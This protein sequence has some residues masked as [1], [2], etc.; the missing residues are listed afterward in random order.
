MM[1]YAKKGYRVFFSRITL[2]DKLGQEYE[3]YIFAALNSAKVMLA[4]GTS[5]DYYNAVWVK[6]EWSRYLQ[7]MTQ[8]KSK[9]LIPCYKDIDA[10]DMPKEFTKLQAQAMGK[11]GAVQDLIRGIEKL[12]FVN[13]PKNISFNSGN[14]FS[15][16]GNIFLKDGDFESAYEYFEK[17]LD[18]N[19]TDATAYLGKVLVSYKV[20]TVEELSK[21]AIMDLGILKDFKH[22]IEFSENKEKRVLQELC[23]ATKINFL[24]IKLIKIFKKRYA[25]LN[26]PIMIYNQATALM[27]DE[28]RTD[29][30]SAMN[31]FESIKDSGLFDDIDEKIEYCKEKLK[32]KAERIEKRRKKAQ[33]N[34]RNLR[35]EEQKRQQHIQEREEKQ[36]LI[37]KQKQEKVERQKKQS[38][39][40]KQLK[41]QKM[42]KFEAEIL[43][44][45]EKRSKF[46]FFAFSEKREIDEQIAKLQDEIGKLR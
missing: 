38:E 21:K 43:A 30:M 44:L 17:A 26:E 24:H 29:Y 14:A 7:L 25:K 31:K 10:Y 40:K 37:E 4:F 11:V 41:K 39:L 34:E 27:E 13:S 32:I 22:A 20:K 8:D 33:E 12:I 19:P 18:Q 6:N 28:T 42:T 16:R 46:G 1:H 23:D 3:P 9:H 45:R 15:V 5:Y 2:E 36:R 35:E